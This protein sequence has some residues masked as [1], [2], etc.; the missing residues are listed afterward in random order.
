MTI[1]NVWKIKIKLFKGN[2]RTFEINTQLLR[3]SN[4]DFHFL[5]MSIVVLDLHK[6]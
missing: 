5:M 6:H 2:Q 4:L 1:G 3:L